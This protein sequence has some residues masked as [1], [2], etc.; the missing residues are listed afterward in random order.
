MPHSDGILQ[1]ESRTARALGVVV[2]SQAWQRT[3]IRW[4]AGNGFTEIVQLLMERG[5]DP[6]IADEDV[7]TLDAPIYG[8][9]TSTTSPRGEGVERTQ[10]E[11][12]PSVGIRKRDA[13]A[14]G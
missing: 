10:P 6:H 9:P 5:A 2:V 4:A 1:W 3:A 11:R 14:I 8:L 13:P 12:R 7:N